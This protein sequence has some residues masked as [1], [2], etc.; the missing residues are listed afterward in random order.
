MPTILLLD[1]ARRRLPEGPSWLSTRGVIL[2][3][4]VTAEE[5]LEAVTASGPVLVIAD[6]ERNPEAGLAAVRALRAGHQVPFLVLAPPDRAD[7]V[8]GAGSVHVLTGEAA[9]DVVLAE[10]R[11][12][13]DLF[14][15]AA[16]RVPVDAPVALWRDGRPTEGR[17]IDISSSGFFT[18]AS[19]P[20]PVG[21]RLEVSFKL[22]H[23]QAGNVDA[24]SKLVTGEVIV[25]RRAPGARSGFGA[26]FFRLPQKARR[27]IDGYLESRAKR[28]EEST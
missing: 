5:A 4:A 7:E 1:G 16:P 18:T 25:V 22:P 11:R 2:L 8:R 23:G 9:P 20:Q 14:E 19:E 10:V 28:T 3:D 15:R 26:R 27:L 12:L 21:A 13:L 17:L 6:L 24:S